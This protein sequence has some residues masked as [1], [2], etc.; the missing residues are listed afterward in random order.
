MFQVM[1]RIVFDTIQTTL[2]RSA[3][4]DCSANQGLTA[5]TAAK[6][7]DHSGVVCEVVVFMDRK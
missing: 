6:I 4:W 1:V 2:G 3:A 5:K 7:T